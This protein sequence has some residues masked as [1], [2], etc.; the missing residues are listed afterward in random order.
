MKVQQE[1]VLVQ[2][3]MEKSKNNVSHSSQEVVSKVTAHTNGEENAKHQYKITKLMGLVLGVYLACTLP[4]VIVLIIRNFMSDEDN[5]VMF[6]VDKIAIL[7][8][9]CQ[10]FLNP[11]IYVWKYK[12]FREAFMKFITIRQA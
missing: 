2:K 3:D 6:V 11:F 10:S 5:K 7:L 9:W 8:W 4:T 1:H 12:T